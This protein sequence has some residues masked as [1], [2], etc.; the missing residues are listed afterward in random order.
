M[1]ITDRFFEILVLCNILTDFIV[2]IHAKK[3][4]AIQN[5]ASSRSDSNENQYIL[6][7][8]KATEISPPLSVNI[9]TT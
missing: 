5:A 9:H 3:L 4:M 7:G 1:L 8:G 2:A 6:G